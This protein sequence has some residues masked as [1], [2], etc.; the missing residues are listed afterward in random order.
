MIVAPSTRRAASA[1]TTLALESCREWPGR[2]KRVTLIDAGPAGSALGCRQRRSRRPAA[3]VRRRRPGA[4]HI[5]PAKRRA[6]GR[7]RRRRRDR[8]P[9]RVAGAD[10]L[11]A[12][13]RRPR[14]DPASQPSPLDGWASAEML[15]LVAEARIYR[16]G[17]RR[18]ASLLN[19]CAC[20]HRACA[21]ELPRRWPTTIRRCS[22]ATIGQRVAFAVAGAIRPPGVQN[23]TTTRPPRAE[24]RGAGGRNRSAR[25]RRAGA[26]SERPI[27]RGFAPA[28]RSR[29][30]DPRPP[31]SSRAGGLNR[32]RCCHH[33]RDA[34]SAR[35]D[36]RSPP[37]R[38]GVTVARHAARLLAREFPDTRETIMTG[39]A[40]SACAAA[41]AV[42]A[43]LDERKEKKTHG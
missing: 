16:P 4:R 2:G 37:F 30:L 31:M 35:P 25:H 21:R 32:W 19:R 20:A 18:P 13:R 5:A 26:M 8:R 15:A 9:P 24:D 23:S 40:A 33:R 39:D 14:A 17:S 29:Q 1:K 42:A 22:A 34:G 41:H 38:R 28:R 12:S 3:P 10:A 36:P 7:T 11:G 27:R 6:A 43:R